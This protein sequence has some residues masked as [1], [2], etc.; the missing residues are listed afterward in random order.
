[1]KQ[2]AAKR[3]LSFVLVACMAFIGLV[4]TPFVSAKAEEYVET[5]FG[6]GKFLITTTFDGATYYLPATTT[7]SGPVAQK[8]TDVNSISSDNLWTVTAKESD[9]YIQNSEG[10]YLYSTNANN[11]MRVGDTANTWTYDASANSFQDTVTKRF[12][13]IY[14]ATNWR[15]YKTVNQTNYKE[16]STSFIFYKISE[17]AASITLEGNTYTEV[18]TPITLEAKTANVTGDIAWTSSNTE[19][20]TVANG[21]VTA[22]TMGTTKITASIGDVKA[23]KEIKV[24]PTADSEIS[25]A[26][27][28]KVC[29]MAGKTNAPYSYSATGVV[30]S[31]DVA[32]SSEH[33][34]ITVTITDGTNSIKAYRMTGGEDLAVGDKITVTGTLVNFSGNTPEFIQ[35]CTYVAIQDDADITAIKD[36]LNAVNAHMSLAFKYTQ[37]TEEKTIV[38]SKEVVF[39]LGANGSATHNDGSEKAT[40]SET[41]DNCTLNITGG[42]KAYTGARD[43]KGN[44]CI[45][46]GTS[47][48]IGSFNFNVPNDVTKVIIA[49]AKYKDDTTKISV[50]GTTHT[51]TK[52]SD[53]GEYD[54]IEVDTSSTK[55]VSLTTVAT[56]Y[57]AMVNSITFMVANS[58][59]GG[60]EK[61]TVYSDSEF[62]L[63]CGVDSSLAEIEGVDSYGIL[64][65]AGEKEEYYNSEA[66]SWNGETAVTYVVISLGDVLNNL[67]RATT[68]FTV[69]AYVVVDGITYVSTQTKTYSVK[70][71]VKEYYNKAE[72]QA[73]VAHL[74][75][76]L[77]AEQA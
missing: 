15:C 44:S 6:A 7:S 16:S 21:V 22:I 1:M 25:I 27:A 47:K 56:T 59:A 77:F 39:E 24:Y 57:R 26:E 8:F 73:Q 14:D 75:N 58:N 18:G 65:S 28:L 60:T 11:G 20:A 13:G 37:S 51:L 48:V 45:K 52:N 5:S 43:A 17:S 54:Q 70:T 72:T 74:Y 33:K 53:N 69:Q 2:T 55:T 36:A 50:N 67:E 42:S 49:V 10:K 40:Y 61:V 68:E 4:T 29:E 46:L 32:Y 30:E 3:I 31:I 12:L 71:I 62:R 66:S 23:E 38:S 19:V 63:K 41:V 9:W 34:N 76:I 35:G 64:V